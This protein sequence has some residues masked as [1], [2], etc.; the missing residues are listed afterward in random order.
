MPVLSRVAFTLFGQPIYWYGIL[1]AVAILSAEL[2]CLSRESRCRLPKDTA[3]NLSLLVIP[4]ALVFARAY[5]VVFAWDQFRGNLW[6]VFDVRSGGMAIYGGIIGGVL[7]GLILSR[8]TRVSFWRLCD[9]VAPAL[10]LGQAI[11]RWGNFINQEAYGYAVAQPGLQFFPFAVYIEANA[12]WHLATFFYESAWCFALSIFLLAYERR[13]ARRF[14]GEL[15]AWY[16]LLYGLERAVVEGLRTDSLMLGP[17]R[18]SQWLS[19]ALAIVALCV[20]VRERRKLK[21]DP[22]K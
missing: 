12:S 10:A 15:F 20:I 17:I 22:T 21:G 13:Q 11:G 18:V 5:Y 19:L 9:L 1:M 4:F 8:R 7:A 14:P 6:S 2:V 16:L 3:I